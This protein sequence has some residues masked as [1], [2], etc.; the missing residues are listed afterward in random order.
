MVLRS[1][2]TADVSV[3]ISS[4]DVTEGTVAPSSV[5]FT[6]GNWNVAQTITVTGVDDAI[7]DGDDRLHDRDRRRPPARIPPTTA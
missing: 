6:G 4:S 1:Q 5:T 2:P 3:G 7:A